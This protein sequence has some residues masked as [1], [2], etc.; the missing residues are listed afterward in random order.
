[1]P[2]LNLPW[3]DTWRADSCW[4]IVVA[5]HAPPQIEEKLIVQMVQRER[6]HLS[7]AQL[8]EYDQQQQQQQE[9][10]QEQQLRCSQ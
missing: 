10:E 5:L 6:S 3:S 4:S 1:M 8:A 2:Q 9:Q 7:P